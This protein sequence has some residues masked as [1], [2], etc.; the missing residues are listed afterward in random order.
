MHLLVCES[1]KMITWTDGYV[2][3]LCVAAELRG[4]A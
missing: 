1:D 3:K 2:I 4:T